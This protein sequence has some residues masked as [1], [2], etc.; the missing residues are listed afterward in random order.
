MVLTRNDG[1]RVLLSEIAD[2]RDTFEEG[3]LTARFNGNPAAIVKVWRVGKEDAIEM[4]ASIHKYLEGYEASLPQGL[5]IAIWNNEAANLQARLDTLNGMALSGLALVVV[6]LALFLKFRLAMWVAAGVPIALLGTLAVFPY[7]DISMSSM[8]VLAFILVLGIL[9]D[10]AIVVGERV[11]AHEQMGKPPVQ[12]AID[13]TW[14][15]SIPVVFGVLTTM[16]AF[17]PLLLATGRMAGFFSVVGWVVVIALVCSIIESQLILPSHLAH[18]NHKEAS[19]GFSKAWNRVQGRL[20]GWLENLATTHYQPLL[21]KAVDNRYITGAVGLGVL[22]LALALIA[23]GRVV[24]TF[25]PSI[26]G[27]RV[28]ATLEMPEGVSVDVTARAAMRLERAATA[29]ESE[30]REMTG[31][32]KVIHNTFT[33]IG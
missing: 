16:A 25:F 7:A 10:D 30:L 17:L 1:T 15:V 26:E 32:D 8:T 24:F 14:E 22:I 31:A 4:S 29:I 33:S 3:D 6:V 21:R 2:I 11:Y 9:V 12:A 23:S 27:D 18:R 19:R 20:S 5:D 28:Y 13:G